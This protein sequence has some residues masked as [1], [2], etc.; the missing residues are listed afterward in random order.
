MRLIFIITVCLTLLTYLGS[1]FIIASSIDSNDQ[2][3]TGHRKKSNNSAVKSPH[4]VT[5]VDPTPHYHVKEPKIL[6][7]KKYVAENPI[8]LLTSTEKLL[9]EDSELINSASTDHD[10]IIEG[11][12]NLTDQQATSPEEPNQLPPSD[13]DPIQPSQN[14]E[15][16]QPYLPAPIEPNQPLPPAP[17]EPKQTL[18]PTP[19]E[20]KQTLPPAPKEPKQPLPPAPKEPKQPLPPAPK[21]PKQR[22]PP[23]PKEPKQPNP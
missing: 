20:P 5:P 9:I 15:P 17:K 18:P 2:L 4:N 8:N 6:S 7:T 1:S 10:E 11:I 16:N 13:E 22:H 19:K 3:K 21:E 23:P 12:I 14:I